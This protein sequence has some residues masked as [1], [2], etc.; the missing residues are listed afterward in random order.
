MFSV[1]RQ[2]KDFF[3]KLH[4]EYSYSHFLSYSFKV[5]TTNTSKHSRIPSKTKTEFRQKQAKSTTVFRPKQ[6]KNHLLQGQQDLH[7]QYPLPPLPGVH[8]SLKFCHHVLQYLAH[9]LSLG[10]LTFVVQ[11]MNQ[12]IVLFCFFFP[13]KPPFSV[14]TLTL[15]KKEHDIRIPKLLV[16]PYFDFGFTCKETSRGTEISACQRDR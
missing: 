13:W 16:H 9:R 8:S 3:Q 15:T 7:N 4:F 11:K 1:E 6:R 10:H 14:K 5:E 2:Q 12:K